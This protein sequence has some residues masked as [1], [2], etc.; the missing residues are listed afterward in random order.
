MDIIVTLRRSID[1]DR[2]DKVDS[3]LLLFSPPLRYFATRRGIQ[4]TFA[5]LGRTEWKQWKRQTK[6]NEN[7]F[8]FSTFHWNKSNK[9]KRNRRNTGA[10]RGGGQEQIAA[11]ERG[12]K[13][14]SQE[15]WLRLFIYYKTDSRTNLDTAVVALT[16]PIIVAHCNRIG[17]TFHLDW[18]LFLSLPTCMSQLLTLRDY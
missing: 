7:G 16:Q 11:K 10:K 2:I 9:N 18:W 1:D 5:H 15:Q 6:N 12:E 14:L 4:S 8:L 3:F 17:V 13:K